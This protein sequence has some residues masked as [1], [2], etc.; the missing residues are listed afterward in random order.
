ML[1]ALVAFVACSPILA[2]R[3]DLSRYFTLTP[4]AD[5]GSASAKL[6]GRTLG[7]GPVTLPQYLDRPE[8]V[9][10]VGPNEV[11]QAKS[12]FWAGSLAKQFS[13]TLTENLRA[14]LGPS[15]IVSYPW[16][17]G[18]RLDVVVEVDVVRFELA[19]DGAAHLVARWRLRKGTNVA[20]A[21]E[22]SFDR[23]VTGDTG[24]TVAALSE[25]LGDLSRAIADAV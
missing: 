22:S 17:P 11:R 4:I 6:A 19:N 23:P 10:R 1:S 20:R 12:E 25:L 3:P 5:A 13:A 14:L 2:P 16:Y 7:I 21:E 24:A 18:T 9:W 8:L 15:E